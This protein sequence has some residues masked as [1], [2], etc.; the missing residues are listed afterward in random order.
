MASCIQPVS[1][2]SNKRPLLATLS[3]PWVAEFGASFLSWMMQ[4]VKLP[5]SNTCGLH[6]SNSGTICSPD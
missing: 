3:H 6:T 4:N 5:V 1:E 2:G